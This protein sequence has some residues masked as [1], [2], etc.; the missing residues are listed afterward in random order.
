M[1]NG[2]KAESATLRLV[3]FGMLLL[4]LFVGLAQV[5]LIDLTGYTATIAAL[6]AS[7]GLLIEIGFIGRLKAVARK[8]YKAFN[9]VT[10]VE[11]L[12]ALVVLVNA[13]LLLAGIEVAALMA[14]SG[15]AL[16]VTSLAFAYEIIV[17]R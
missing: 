2:I 10:L 5:G 7:V 6:I 12:T 9:V 1:A 11:A 14:I 8:N 13:G 3:A 15:W 17:I 16:L 4:I